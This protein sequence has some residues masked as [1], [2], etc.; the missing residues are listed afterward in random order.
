MP[1][2]MVVKNIRSFEVEVGGRSK[3]FN[4]FKRRYEEITIRSGII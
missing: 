4:Q 1:S 3:E 2:I